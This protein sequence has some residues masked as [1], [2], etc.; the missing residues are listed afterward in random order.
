[1]LGNKFAT[2]LN[3]FSSNFS[4]NYFS[5]IDLINRAGKVNDLTDIDLN[6]PDHVKDDF[7][8]TI[9]CVKDNGLNINGFATI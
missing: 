5:T 2:R 1:M 9:N 8:S 7:K 3:S 4:N 6:Y